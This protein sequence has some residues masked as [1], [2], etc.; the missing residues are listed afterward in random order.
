M[1]CVGTKDL[2]AKQIFKIFDKRSKGFTTLTDMKAILG[3][4]V[5]V[6]VTDEE[7]EI[8]FEQMSIDTQADV[9]LQD[10]TDY[11]MNG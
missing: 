5:D 7:L 11:L 10:L 3:R 8:L 6:P 4:V 1:G 2:E 9:T